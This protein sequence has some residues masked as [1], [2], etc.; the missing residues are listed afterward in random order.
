MNVFHRGLVA[1]QVAALEAHQPT[2][3]GNH[4]VQPP[5]LREV[6]FA[7]AGRRFTQ[8]GLRIETALCL[9]EAFSIDVRSDYGDRFQTRDASRCRGVLVEEDSNRIRLFAGRAAGAPHSQLV[10]SLLRTPKPAS[11]P[12]ITLRIAQERDGSRL[13]RSA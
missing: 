11:S 2:H 6:G 13:V 7:Q 8:R 9:A 5:N 3:L 12:R 4:R 10:L 1:E